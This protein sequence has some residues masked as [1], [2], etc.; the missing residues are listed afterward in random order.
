MIIL[1]RN[2]YIDMYSHIRIYLYSEIIFE[3]VLIHSC[4]THLINTTGNNKNSLDNE[5]VLDQ[6]N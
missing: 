5:N 4:K 3:N 1:K 2:E 6:Q